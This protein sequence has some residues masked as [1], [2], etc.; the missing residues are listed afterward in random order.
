MT[1]LSTRDDLAV[2]RALAAMVAY[3]DLAQA[4][5]YLEEQGYQANVDTLRTMRDVQFRDRF[6]KVRESLAPRIE[7]SLANDFLD[8]ARMASE[9]ERLAVER[10]RQL[11]G[12]GKIADPSRVARDLS[13]V[14]TQS[15]DKRLA[16]Q[17]RPT[18]ITEHRD[19]R[20]I[21]RALE[22]MKVV[23]TVDATVVPELGEANGSESHADP[24]AAV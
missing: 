1:W 5:S 17:G 24:A 2:E 19:P 15:V 9:V 4:S 16:L 10:T 22:A 6:E 11:L 14:K 21:I 18:Q 23:Q 20:E 3:P 7:A 8:N 12:E 13:Q